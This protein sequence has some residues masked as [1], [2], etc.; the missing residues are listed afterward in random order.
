MTDRTD[1]SHNATMLFPPPPRTMIPEEAMSMADLVRSWG[2]REILSSRLAYRERY[3][4][5][6]GDRL[7]TLRSDLGLGDLL[8][9]EA[10]GGLGL[11]TSRMA[12]GAVTILIELA[13]A[14]AS[15]AFVFALEY[16]L[17]A[18]VA[19][20]PH[21]DQ[22]CC[23]LIANRSQHGIALALPGA[24]VIG[25]EASLFRGKVLG[26]HIEHSGSKGRLS[27]GS[28]RVFGA[29]AGK[30]T[31]LVVASSTDNGRPCL[32]LVDGQSKGVTWA[33]RLK[34]T[35]L[36]AIPMSDVMLEGVSV[37]DSRLVAGGGPLSTLVVW[38]DLLFGAV[39]LGA[40]MDFFEILSRWSDDRSIKGREKL[41]EN[42]LCAALL[43]QVA[44][45]IAA[46]TLLLYDLAE[47]VAEDPVGERRAP[48]ERLFA[49]AQL[50]G[51]RIQRGAFTAIDRGLELMGSAGYAKEWHAEKHWRDVKTIK[52]LLCGPGGEVPAQLDGAR[53][54][55]GIEKV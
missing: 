20:E 28:L 12:P 18:I 24:G 8:L 47:M 6:F 31:L 21:V 19:I 34:T 41:K 7:S 10:Q 25:E 42:P 22:S 33:P 45:E 55:F 44:G 43:A 40:A 52:T 53:Y 30:G 3:G 50:L 13:R 54:F 39:S 27:G 4:E 32:A 38:L 23:D 37:D 11:N 49:F 46:S 15:L 9:P 35:G 29:S 1:W 14:D 26:A 51:A 16:A 36:E 2:R 5:L 17:E 48:T